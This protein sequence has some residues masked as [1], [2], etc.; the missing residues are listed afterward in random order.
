MDKTGKILIGVVAVIAITLATL[1]YGLKVSPISMRL[2][3]S[4]NENSTLALKGYDPVAYFNQGKA[5]KGDTSKGIRW[6]NVIWYF[7][8]DANK[9]MFKTFPEKYVPQYGGY[10]A[11]A[12]ASGFT[13]DIDPMIWHIENGKLFLFFDQGSK[14]S[15][16]NAINTG[17][18]KKASSEWAKR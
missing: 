13:A 12:V 8:S 1:F 17:I 18:I 5:I 10:C 3:G 14:N 7:S 16:V 11:G 6:G 2:V 9:L 15:F 4:I